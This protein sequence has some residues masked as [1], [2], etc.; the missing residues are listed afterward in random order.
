MRG[1]LTVSAALVLMLAGCQ[2][3]GIE[4]EPRD[5]EEDAPPDMAPRDWRDTPYD[6]PL[7]YRPDPGSDPASDA[8]TSGLVP[9]SDG[10]VLPVDTGH[11]DDV[12][13]DSYFPVAFSGDVYELVLRHR[14]EVIEDPERIGIFRLAA[15]G[16]VLGSDWLHEIE[17]ERRW[18]AS[19]CWSGELFTILVPLEG[20]GLV[21]M[22]VGEDG[23]LARAPEVLGPDAGY[24]PVVESSASFVLCPDG[25]P[26]VVDHGRGEGGLDRL[27][28]LAGDGSTD[29]SFVDVDMPTLAHQHW[30]PV[31]T[32]LGS[33]AV[34]YTER[35]GLAL[36]GLVFFDRSGTI[37]EAEPEPELGWSE[38]FSLTAAGDDLA[39]TWT[40]YVSGKQY[41]MF[42]LVDGDGEV[43]VPANSTGIQLGYGPD[44]GMASVSSGEHVFVAANGLIDPITEWG[45]PMV[46]L[47]DLEGHP[48]GDGLRLDEIF[49]PEYREGR[50][51]AVFWEGDAY[52][53]L[54]PTGPV[55]RRFTV[56]D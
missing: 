34:C 46:F 12:S 28:L 2:S 22:A 36:F 17:R 6:W 8:P 19:I 44:F 51:V 24:M 9:E 5:G 55:Y 4:G 26:I 27:H 35:S 7:E 11:W 45:L 49:D 14:T 18:N 42:M 53:V 48:I 47:V 31:C 1:E 3:L 25:G 38:G 43:L 15:G 16:T 21:L 40:A 13:G 54:Y 37:R 10:T 30:M 52:T 41:L 32:T 39:L 20:V 56:V 29:G 50:G 33:D 23:V